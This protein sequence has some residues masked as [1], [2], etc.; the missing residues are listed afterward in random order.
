MYR[1]L[2]LRAVHCPASRFAGSS[3][4]APRS[5]AT[6]STARLQLPGESGALR[7]L[8]TRPR[9]RRGTRSAASTADRGRADRGTG[10]SAAEHRRAGPPSHGVRAT[11]RRPVPEQPDR[12]GAD[13]RTHT[14][15]SWRRA[16]RMGAAD[17]EARSDARRPARS[18]AICCSRRRRPRRRHET[19]FSFAL[20]LDAV[21]QGGP[22]ARRRSDRRHG[23]PGV[24]GPRVPDLAS[25][26]P[27]LL[28]PG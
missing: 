11:D 13:P 5:R 3:R 2:V 18:T 1:W 9:D 16:G 26:L 12:P 17:A 21:S 10:A 27:E 15:R 24:R 20:N 6:T 8:D 25:P 19:L 23:S 7:V 4:T 14:S 22:Q 28:V